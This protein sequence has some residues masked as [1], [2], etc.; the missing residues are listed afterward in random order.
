MEGTIFGRKDTRKSKQRAFLA[1]LLLAASLCVTT[2]AAA[3][4]SFD[5]R[6][7]DVT[8]DTPYSEAILAAAED[9]YVNGYT[10]SAFHPSDKLTTPMLMT[11]CGRAFFPETMAENEETAPYPDYVE[12]TMVQ[13]HLMTKH[14]TKNERCTWYSSIKL[15][16]CA[17]NEPIYSQAA[18][19]DK[20]EMLST[21]TFPQRA[22]ISTARNYGLFDGLEVP[23]DKLNQPPTRGEFMQLLWNLLQKKGVFEKP[24]IG[25]GVPIIALDESITLNEF[26]P[27]Y[28]ALWE[29]P[30]HVLSTFKDEEW[31][32]AITKEKTIN[33]LYPVYKDYP[34]ISGMT[35]Q[36]KRQIIL[37]R[38]PAGI[39]EATVLHE[40]GHFI[41]RNIASSLPEDFFNEERSGIQSSLRNYAAS[42]SDEAFADIF[43]TICLY[44][45]DGV[46]SIEVRD[47][48][49]K[50]FKYVYQS[51][52]D[53]PHTKER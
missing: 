10:D 34:T 3:E 2:A 30:T 40:F 38:E 1:G 47:A 17:A 8:E 26:S 51:C 46:E 29:L 27:I 13:H 5:L 45:A 22:I 32:I 44:G 25:E 35:S 52:F 33:E 31:S 16:L 50:C 9:G 41:H 19:G 15:L 18:W 23:Q 36:K 28:E 49:P 43:A 6:F 7:P 39:S 24:L 42:T 37:Y 48:A 4:N 21:I 11:I 20:T 53:V 12:D 14:Q